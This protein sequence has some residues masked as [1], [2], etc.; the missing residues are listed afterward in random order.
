AAGGGGAPGPSVVPVALARHGLRVRFCEA[1]GRC[2]DARF[3]FPEPVRDV[4]GLRH[5]MHTLF[6]AAAR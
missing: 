5:A 2:F 3:E 6:E 1:D 4:T